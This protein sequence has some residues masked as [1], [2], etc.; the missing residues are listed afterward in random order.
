MGEVS[1]KNPKKPDNFQAWR[2]GQ[3]KEG[4]TDD[5]GWG[6]VHEGVFGAIEDPEIEGGRREEKGGRGWGERW[7][8]AWGELMIW[9]FL[10]FTIC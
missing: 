10:K 8:T 5:E 9:Q 1:L 6:E 4:A 2:T 7:S 3:I